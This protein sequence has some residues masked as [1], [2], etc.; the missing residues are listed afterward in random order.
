M[1]TVSLLFR[2]RDSN[3]RSQEGNNSGACELA[4]ENTFRREN[5]VFLQ[6]LVATGVAKVWSVFPRFRA[7][8][9]ERD[10]EKC[11]STWWKLS[12][13]EHLWKMRSEKSARDCSKSSVCSSKL[14]NKLRHSERHGKVRTVD[15]ARTFVD[16]S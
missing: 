12:R 16:L 9:W 4:G 7:S 8:I 10:R 5:Y 13:S 6:V 15:A 3:A 14:L 2:H 11:T 1:S